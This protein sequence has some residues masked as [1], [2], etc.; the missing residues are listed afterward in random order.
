MK[1]S[2]QSRRFLEAAGRFLRK[3]SAG[4]G[5]KPINYSA[6]GHS[7]KREPDDPGNHFGSGYSGAPSH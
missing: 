7:K 1:S 6:S 4:L 3:C 2:L 5:A